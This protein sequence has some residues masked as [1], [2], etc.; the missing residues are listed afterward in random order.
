MIDMKEKPKVWHDRWGTWY[1]ATYNGSGAPTGEKIPVKTLAYVEYGSR[2]YGTHDEHSDW[3]AYKI[4][5]GTEI[6][7]EQWGNSPFEQRGRPSDRNEVMCSV[8]E[9]QK[10]LDAHDVVALE[11]YFQGQE[12]ESFKSL[13]LEFNLD[14][15]KLR[16]VFSEKIS[17]SWVK[18]K[19]LLEVEAPQYPRC[20]WRYVEEIYRGKKSLFHSL[21]ITRFGI[22][23]AKFGQIHDFQECAKLHKEIMSMEDENWQPYK[24][25]YQPLKNQYMSE[26]RELA[27]KA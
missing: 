2:V 6:K 14:I 23:I 21:R 15:A 1:Y 10:V 9:F 7:V 13:G 22:Q 11:V 26:F 19:K 25:K 12:N 17:H 4:V 3:D 24:D 20:D 16:H 5:D 18:A 27:P 8:D